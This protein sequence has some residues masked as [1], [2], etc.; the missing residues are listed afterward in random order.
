MFT[1]FALIALAL[2]YFPL[3]FLWE[4]LSKK[5]FSLEILNYYYNTIF[6][7]IFSYTCSIV[8]GKDIRAIIDNGDK[9]SL[10]FWTSLL[11]VIFT[12][13]IVI[14]IILQVVKNI[15]NFKSSR[16][17]IY[18]IHI[19]TAYVINVIFIF[20][21]IYFCIYLIIPDSFSGITAGASHLVVYLDLIYFSF[22]TF[23]TIGYGDISPLAIL[24]KGVVVLQII[25]FYIV[26]G[27]GFTFASKKPHTTDS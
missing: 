23:A 17:H 24:G 7:A 10:S 8:L 27:I 9:S 5:H 14:K 18:A 1:N 2:L 21:F 20:A 13:L 26:I 16:E 11:G 12:L 3:L 4:Y 6:F 15:R 19:I 22:V 25:L